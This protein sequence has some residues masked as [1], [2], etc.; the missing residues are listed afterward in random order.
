MNSIEQD[1][2]IADLQRYVEIL[3]KAVISLQT[4]VIRINEEELKKQ[5]LTQSS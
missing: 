2:A 3:Q 5:T 1:K 4:N